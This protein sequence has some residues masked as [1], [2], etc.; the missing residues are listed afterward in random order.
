MNNNLFELQHVGYSI[1]KHQGFDQ[2]IL[3]NVS[4]NVSNGEI[5]AILGKSGCGKSTLLRII[6]GIV[7][8]TTGQTKFYQDNDEK[9]FGISMVFQTF[10]LFPWMTVLENVEL[11]LE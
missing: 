4:F 2:E 1:A 10:A 9:S 11:G 8:P 6:A 5:I 7:N 3:D